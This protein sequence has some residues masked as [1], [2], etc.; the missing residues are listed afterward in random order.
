[1]SERPLICITGPDRGGFFPWIMTKIAIFRAGGKSIR[2]TPSKNSNIDINKIEGVII[3]GGTDIDPANYGEEFNK[4]NKEIEGHTVK[5]RIIAILMLLLRMI[6]S[7]KTS[8]A[9]SDTKRDELE[10]RICQHAVRQKIPVLGICR[11]AQM[12]NICLGGTLHQ[13][14]R[15]FY[16]ETPQ[17][18]TILPRKLVSLTAGSKLNNILGTST[19]YVNSLHDQAINS[20]GQDLKVS[21]TDQNGIIQGVESTCNSFLIGVQWHPE[22][23]PQ[24]VQQQKIFAALVKNAIIQKSWH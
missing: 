9:G 17:I 6:F 20:L 13:E 3:G 18:K 1:M 5:N 8:K 7:I 22:Y 21:A 2:I 10:K 15:Q 14:T 19:C 24:S 4:I 23:L 11:G 12:L 16:S